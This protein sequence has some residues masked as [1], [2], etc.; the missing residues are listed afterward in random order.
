MTKENKL[1][2]E[3]VSAEMNKV[4]NNSQIRNQVC[5]K[6]KQSMPSRTSKIMTV[7]SKTISKP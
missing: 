3:N 1:V 2:K 6:L 7:M 5:V 4:L